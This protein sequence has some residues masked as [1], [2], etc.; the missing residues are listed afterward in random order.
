MAN[1]E[2]PGTAR[3]KSSETTG[4]KA[5][6]LKG[7]LKLASPWL[8][9]LKGMSPEQLKR[10]PLTDN[11]L[12]LIGREA[13]MATDGRVL[14]DVKVSLDDVKNGNVPALF[15]FG[16]PQEQA[17]Y[18]MK[19]QIPEAGYARL[20]D[21]QEA[22]ANANKNFPGQFKN[23]N[24]LVQ[25]ARKP[26][27][28]RALDYSSAADS[29]KHINKHLTPNVVNAM[30]EVRALNGK[31]LIGTPI[32]YEEFMRQNPVGQT[33]FKGGIFD[34]A[35]WPENK[36]GWVSGRPTVALGYALNPTVFS[37][38]GDTHKISTL[39]MSKSRTF[40]NGRT[41]FTPHVAAGNKR[42][43][44]NNI[45]D[46]IYFHSKPAIAD[47][48]ENY[49]AVLPGHEMH[50]MPSRVFNIEATGEMPHGQQIR[51]MMDER[52]DPATLGLRF[53]EIDPDAIVQQKAMQERL[54]WHRH[55]LKNEQE[56]LKETFKPRN[57]YLVKDTANGGHD[58]NSYK[59]VL[60]PNGPFYE[61]GTLGTLLRYFGEQ[62][63]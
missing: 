50:R 18:A 39:P 47:R 56:V 22:L 24:D 61:K 62:P 54:D 13:D 23:L 29:I 12:S 2:T 27:G 60:A 34:Q 40:R 32:T 58:W 4:R 31:K 14:G 45:R 16:T 35:N 37:W 41:F 33:F 55:Q 46:G 48:F 8:R 20:M 26:R 3:T 57:S 43:R 30:K 10:I 44:I 59:R 42:T 6:N 49:E 7:L 51:D 11:L 1:S 9:R 17:R 28:S 15:R 36:P 53:Q 63:Q 38:L 25:L 19:T 5:R 52:L 21:Y